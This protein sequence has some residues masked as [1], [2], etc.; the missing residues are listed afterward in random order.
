MPLAVIAIG[1]NSLVQVHQVGTIEEQFENARITCEGIADMIAQGWDVVLTHGNGPQVGNVM[2]RVELASHEIY[3]LPL[4]VCDADTEGGMG[5]MLQQV[6]GNALSERGI[7]RTVVTLVTQVEVD[8]DDPA[9]D[10][11][12]KPVGPWYN[13]EKARVRMDTMGWVMTHN[14][15]RGWRR[16]VPSPGP[17]RIVEL[18]AIRRCSGGGL[19][20]IA[21]GGGGVPVVTRDG[22]LYGVEA[23]IDKD[24]ASAMLAAALNADLLLISTGVETVMLGYDTPEER[25]L[26]NVDAAELRSYQEAGEFPAGSMGPKVEAAL[27]YLAHCDGVVVITDPPNLA[28]AVRGET[29]TRVCN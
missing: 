18:E 9:F 1:G 4:D 14:A 25:A 10:N 28:R 13:E 20:P 17:K 26:R 29:G 2:L 15:R 6:L 23:V 8:A 7:E 11:P 16:L 12:T 27:A 22:R 19:I 21:V 5:Y 24:R 3:P